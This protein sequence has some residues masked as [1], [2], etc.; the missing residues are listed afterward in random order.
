MK[1]QGEDESHLS[2]GEKIVQK[3]C[4]YVHNFCFTLIKK[5]AVQYN[6]SIVELL[7][8]GKFSTIHRFSL[9]IWFFF[10]RLRSI[11]NEIFY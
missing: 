11:P 5:P 9:I 4:T 2:C 6:L 3:K 7:V 8:T 1:T 10:V